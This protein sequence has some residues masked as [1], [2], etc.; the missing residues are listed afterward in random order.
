MT[1]AYTLEKIHQLEK[2]VNALIKIIESHD[3]E[4]QYAYDIS[5][6]QQS[7]LEEYGKRIRELESNNG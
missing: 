1:D 5:E 3:T 2:T 6:I 4:L 7:L